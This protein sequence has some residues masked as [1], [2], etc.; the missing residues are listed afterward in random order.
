MSISA[1][2]LAWATSLTEILL[3]RSCV[4]CG[5]DC[6]QHNVCPACVA[7]LPR[8]PESSCP[9]CAL[10]TPDAAVCGHCLK[11]APYFDATRSLYRYDFPADKLIQALKYRRRL[12]SADF[13]SRALAGLPLDEHPDLILPVP[14]AP[15]RLAARGFNQALELARPLAKRLQVPIELAAV[16]RC[17][18]TAPQVSLPWK[19]RAGNISHAFECSVDLTGKTVLVVDDVMTTGA[20]LNELARVL[21]AHGARR[22]VNRVVARAL[23]HQ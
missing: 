18:E 5:I 3:P 13:L 9:V 16:R 2:I 11:S 10:P 15:A 8:L 19:A 7:R 20:T 12:A 22:V 6:R 14:L 17:R 1:P 23:R 21:K 4:L